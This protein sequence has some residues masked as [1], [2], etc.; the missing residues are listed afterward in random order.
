MAGTIGGINCSFIHGTPLGKSQRT[1]VWE[2]PGVNGYGV[3]VTGLGDS[4]FQIEAV[5]IG[6]ASGLTIWC[7]SITALK[8]S[9]ITIVKYVQ[10]TAITYTGAVI[11]KIGGPAITPAGSLIRASLVLEGVIS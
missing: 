3:M 7:N 1:I 5:Y 2:V 9:P 11:R 8:G 6:A 4:E 10:S